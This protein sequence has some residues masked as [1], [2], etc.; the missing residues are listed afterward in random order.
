MVLGGWIQ[1]G[2]ASAYLLFFFAAIK[3]AGDYRVFTG[4]IR[5]QDLPVPGMSRLFVV[6]YVLGLLILGV[7]GVLVDNYGNRSATCMIFVMSLMFLVS[8]WMWGMSKT[9][10][11]QR[12]G[13]TPPEWLLPVLMTIP[14]AFSVVMVI[15]M[16][17]GLAMGGDQLTMRMIAICWIVSHCT[18]SLLTSLFS[19]ADFTVFLCLQIS[20]AGGVA[21]LI[22]LYISVYQI[23]A[24]LLK[25]VSDSQAAAGGGKTKSVSGDHP[26]HPASSVVITPS[27]AAE[28]ATR[29]AAHQPSIAYAVPIASTGTGGG[30]G[31]ASGHATSD[32]D[33]TYVHAAI[34]RLWLQVG[35]GSAIVLVA[36]VRSIVIYGPGMVYPYDYQESSESDRQ[37]VFGLFAAV[38]NAFPLFM[39]VAA[40]PSRGQSDPSLRNR[41][42]APTAGN[43]GDAG[44]AGARTIGVRP[45]P[46]PRMT[47]AVRT[48]TT[49]PAANTGNS[50]PVTL[51]LPEAR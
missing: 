39:V 38:Y 26:N 11:R 16:V 51:A 31:G 2:I 5:V 44:R 22:V 30:V 14:I 4:H 50:N 45:P 46:S 20:C 9:V 25:Y 40:W 10:Y 23:R 27:P 32:I 15:V 42:V 37:D 21:L 6:V 41:K 35:V 48:P 18:C 24:N 19:W 33:T 28:P 49:Q 1:I 43:G 3:I 8:G 47:P 36:R 12:M 17:I 34:R 7:Q 29:S 13:Q